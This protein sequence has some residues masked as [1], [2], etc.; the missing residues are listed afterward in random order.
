MYL[1]Q[2]SFAQRV[3]LSHTSAIY[4][5]SPIAM[6][7]NA[8]Q[9]VA[10]CIA[11]CCSVCCSV[12]QRVL[13]CGAVCYSLLPQPCAREALQ[14]LVAAR[15]SVLHCVL[16][17]VA[18]CVAVCCIVLLSATSAI[19]PSHVL[20]RAAVCCIVCCSVLQCVLHYVA[21]C[22]CVAICVAVCCGV[23]LSLT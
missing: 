9:F 19:H 14:P 12:L 6:C 5:R 16:N 1:L 23:L 22:G 7:Y 17:F 11:M 8:L 4:P 20:Q 21:V 2:G 13:Q 18:V 10:V 15:C 3:L